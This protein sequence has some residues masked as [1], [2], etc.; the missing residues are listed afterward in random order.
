MVSTEHKSL[1]EE[2]MEVYGDYLNNLQALNDLYYLAL[3]NP[4]NT[5]QITI[6][7]TAISLASRVGSFDRYVQKNQSD[8]PT[9]Q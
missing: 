4:A 3:R 8:W 9:K 7:K 5:R 6:L 2:A 1:V